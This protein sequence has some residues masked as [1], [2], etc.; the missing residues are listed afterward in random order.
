[1][2]FSPVT[3][4]NLLVVVA[5]AVLLAATVSHAATRDP[6]EHF[7]QQSFGD[8]SEEQTMALE[9]GKRGIFI[10]FEDEDCPW[11]AKMKARVLNQVEVQDYFRKHF[12]ILSVDINGD[13]LITDFRGNEITQKAYAEKI[14]V[15]ATPVLV[16]YDLEGNVAV[17]YTGAVRNTQEFM[18]LGEFVVDGHYQTTSFPQ[19]KRAKKK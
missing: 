3:C 10:M 5:V 12:R 19:Y 1:M 6:A 8:F 7:F 9:E 17:R 14:R 18:W 15:R 2:F 13:E 4:K 16:I 11:C